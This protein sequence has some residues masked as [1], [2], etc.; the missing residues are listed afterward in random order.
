[1]PIESPSSPRQPLLQPQTPSSS[2]HYENR[3]GSKVQRRTLG[4]RPREPVRKGA[5]IPGGRDRTPMDTPKTPRQA[6]PVAPQP[7][8]SRNKKTDC[9]SHTPPFTPLGVRV[10]LSTARATRGTALGPHL[11]IPTESL[12]SAREP[13]LRPSTPPTQQN[14][15][16]SVPPPSLA[17]NF[18]FRGGALRKGLDT[19]RESP[20]APSCALG[21]LESAASR[22]PGS[23]YSP[24][25]RKPHT[26]VRRPVELH[27]VRFGGGALRVEPQGW[28]HAQRTGRYA[29]RE[30]FLAAAAPPATPNAHK[31]RTL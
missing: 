30:P 21:E 6:P 20:R 8:N 13:N 28:R 16:T 4:E 1:M 9:V 25:G 5:R 7:P 3:L 14:I 15:K 23:P 29:H 22:A 18:G 31:Q 17:L 26:G 12:P 11:H 27:P 2:A 19:G 24:S 10:D